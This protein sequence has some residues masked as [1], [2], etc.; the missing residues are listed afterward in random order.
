VSPETSV[1]D[2]R[3]KTNSTVMIDIDDNDE[4]LFIIIPPFKPVVLAGKF[5]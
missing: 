5:Q 4:L 2:S 1:L 3:V